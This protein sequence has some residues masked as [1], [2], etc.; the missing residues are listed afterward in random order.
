MRKLNCPSPVLMLSGRTSMLVRTRAST[1]AFALC[2]QYQLFR[3][4]ILVPTSAR[5]FCKYVSVVVAFRYLSW[6]RRNCK[7][8]STRSTQFLQARLWCSLILFPVHLACPFLRTWICHWNWLSGRVPEPS[9]DWW[10]CEQHDRAHGAND[11]RVE[12]C[13]LLD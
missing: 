7:L 9:A 1:R 6:P 4:R 5:P 12:D 10:Y 13:G 8:V 11:H 3:E 2:T